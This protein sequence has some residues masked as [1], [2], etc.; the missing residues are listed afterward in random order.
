MQTNKKIMH[1]GGNPL[2]RVL[3]TRQNMVNNNSLISDLDNPD[4]KYTNNATNAYISLV[5]HAKSRELMNRI[6]KD[7]DINAY[8]KLAKLLTE[9]DSCSLSEFSPIYTKKICYQNFLQYYSI[10]DLSEIKDLK[11]I[12]LNEI[13]IV[14]NEGLKNPMQ[15]YK[16]ILENQLKLTDDKKNN[17]LIWVLHAR[18]AILLVLNGQYITLNGENL[19]PIQCWRHA[20]KYGK[21]SQNKDVMKFLNVLSPTK[22]VGRE[23]ISQNFLKSL[24]ATVREYITT[25][26]SKILIPFEDLK[27][28]QKSKRMEEL[29]NNILNKTD[30]INSLIELSFYMPKGKEIIIGEESFDKDSLSVLALEAIY[31]IDNNKLKSHHLH[32]LAKSKADDI[33][34]RIPFKD[35]Y[36]NV[37]SLY[38]EAI[39]LNPY[40]SILYLELSILLGE[41][42]SEEIGGE[43]YTKND[44]IELANKN[45]EDRLLNLGIYNNTNNDINKLKENLSI[46]LSK[47]T[48]DID[49]QTVNSSIFGSINT[50]EVNLIVAPEEKDNMFLEN[51]EKIVNKNSEVYKIF[52]DYIQ[53]AN[54][55]ENRVSE[56]LILDL[57]GQK[58]KELPLGFADIIRHNTI[59]NLNNNK[60]FNIANLHLEEFS[61]KY[62]IELH[63][64]DN[65]WSDLDL[66]E[67]LI[68][69]CRLPQKKDM[70]MIFMHSNKNQGKDNTDAQSSNSLTSIRAQQISKIYKKDINITKKVL[71]DRKKLGT[72]LEK[73][74]DAQFNEQSL[75]IALNYIRKNEK[76]SDFY[77]IY[78]TAVYRFLIRASVIVHNKQLPDIEHSKGNLDYIAQGL[79][80]SGTA[81]MGAGTVVG[82]AS[83]A[84]ASG[85]TS[86]P[87]A[88]PA[89]AIS[90]KTLGSVS[91]LL[92]GMLK[93]NRGHSINQL[94]SNLVPAD[95]IIQTSKNLALFATMS[96]RDNLIDNNLDEIDL[97][98]YIRGFFLNDYSLLEKMHIKPNKLQKNGPDNPTQYLRKINKDNSNI[99]LKELEKGQEI[100]AMTADAININVLNL[101]LRV[102]INTSNIAINENNY[103]R[104]LHHGIG[105][106]FFYVEGIN[107]TFGEI[108]KSLIMFKPQTLHQ[109]QDEKSIKVYNQNKDTYQVLTSIP[110]IQSYFLRREF[111]ELADYSPENSSFQNLTKII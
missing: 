74:I 19:N 58:I 65:K 8:L 69:N 111:K 97:S 62:L 91:N 103:E 77:S 47:K 18:L 29:E 4:R 90:L 64:S 98:E 105:K 84:A 110:R 109:N 17:D 56:Q 99:Y 79:I 80:I 6:E 82:A 9:K 104:N 101:L 37:I 60:L 100:K 2:A 33:G 45:E 11:D 7:N 42:G 5:D 3:S 12:R 66:V 78:S 106:F 94:L 39:T 46:N 43:I 36:E 61:H 23:D 68:F 75:D 50:I 71:R 57:S 54:D 34:D 35:S 44:L 24:S 22:L 53:A 92:L 40:N 83:A 28:A 107:A 15:I 102:A 87:V 73:F 20:K 89:A 52:T 85:G 55:R 21:K 14:T 63:L 51:L 41:K 49:N 95:K 16:K 48:Y 88:I 67:M 72:N 96:L 38:K 86:I 108:L 27:G 13:S 10:K 76:L 70:S 93:N 30:T 32:L 59:I 81:L 26:S 31:E 25:S 1:H